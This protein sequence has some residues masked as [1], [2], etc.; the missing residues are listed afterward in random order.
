MKQRK[1]YQ[2]TN[3]IQKWDKTTGPAPS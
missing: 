3:H 2:N 1:I